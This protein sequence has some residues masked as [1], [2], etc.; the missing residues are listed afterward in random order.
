MDTNMADYL[1]QN[2][3][4]HHSKLIILTVKLV[5]TH[6]ETSRTSKTLPHCSTQSTHYYGQLI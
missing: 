4:I 2:L 1:Y 6:N 3:I 5:R